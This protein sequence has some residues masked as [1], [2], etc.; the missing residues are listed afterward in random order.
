[1]KADCSWKTGAGS[2]ARSGEVRGTVQEDLGN[3]F[4]RLDASKN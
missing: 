3:R 2:G 1:M 4:T